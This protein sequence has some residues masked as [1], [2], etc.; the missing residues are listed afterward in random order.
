M[1]K[2]FAACHHIL[3]VDDDERIRD[4]VSRYL[5]QNDFVPL[6]AASAN[7]AEAIMGKFDVDAL[8][9]DIM[10][11]G[12]SGLEFTKKLRQ[13]EIDLPILLLTALGETSDRIAGFEIGADEYLPK[14][15][16]PQELVLRLKAMLRR[17]PVQLPEEK[18]FRVGRWV[19]MPDKKALHDGDN[20][21]QLTTTQESL[22]LALAGRSGEVVARDEL[23]E[24][25]GIETGERTIDVQVTRLRK[26]IEE[27]GKMPKY[28]QTVRGKGYL[29]HIEDV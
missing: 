8:V 22:L 14:P 26:K 19:Y 23:A 28:L 2:E 10:M 18:P 29:L 1:K 12:I 4:L 11:P 25:C 6:S 16:D 27:D 24:L 17:K 13:T 5:M 20:V 21:I 9:L 3:V 7:E 15:F